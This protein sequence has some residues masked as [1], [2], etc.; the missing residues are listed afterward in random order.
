MCT[1]LVVLKNCGTLLI[2]KSYALLSMPRLISH[3]APS[4]P[5]GPA[6]VRVTSNLQKIS[7]SDEPPR[8]RYVDGAEFLHFFFGLGNGERAREQK[9]HEVNCQVRAQKLRLDK[10][11][12]ISPFLG[13]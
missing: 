13:R 1:L 9:Q 12:A 4:L 2:L 5:L 10:F 8:E 7:I 6:S 3:P 11:P